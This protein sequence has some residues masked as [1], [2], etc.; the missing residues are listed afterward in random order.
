MGDIVEV[1]V[2]VRITKEL[3]E[4]MF[5]RDNKGNRLLIE[6]GE[7]DEEGFYVPTIVVDYTDNIV[8]DARW[9]D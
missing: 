3:M 5:T 4:Q 7:A 1:I 6:W 8:R 2:K 9:D